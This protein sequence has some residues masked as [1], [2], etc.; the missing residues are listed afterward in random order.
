MIALCGTM[1]N[2]IIIILMA[3]YWRTLGLEFFLIGAVIDGI[4]GSF[5]TTMAAT[6]A[7]VADCTTPERRAVSFAHVHSVFF[8]GMAVGPAIG[9]LLINRTGSVITLFY[10]SLAVH[11][12]FA[13]FILFLIPESVTPENMIGARN[14]H[15]RRRLSANGMP[16][17]PRQWGYWN[18]IFNI[19]QPLQIFWPKGRGQAFKLKR[20][21]LMILG[22]VDGILLLS[23]GAFVVIILYPKYMFNW[24]DLEVCS[25][26]SPG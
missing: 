3:K 5:T 21:N 14:N 26:A 2:D 4:S 16:Y 8:L 20:R 9:G 10:C 25:T 1:L 7:Y 6:N 18:N 23:L 24:S 17:S 11:I 22:I 13:L 12:S 15:N 19:F